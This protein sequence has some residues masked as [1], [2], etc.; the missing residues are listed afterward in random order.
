MYRIVK[1]FSFSVLYC[2]F[3]L[4][5]DY[6]CGCIYGYNY[7]IIVELVVVMLNVQGFVCE[8][9]ELWLLRDYLD[10]QLDYWYLNDVLGDDCVILE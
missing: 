9:V 2:L 3:G 6:F 10:D 8:Y 5:M 4:V 7:V 1:E